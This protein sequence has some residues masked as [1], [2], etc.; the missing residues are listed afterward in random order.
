MVPA[1]S[2]SALSDSW[3]QNSTKYVP[4]LCQLWMAASANAPSLRAFGS[5]PSTSAAQNFFAGGCEPWLFPFRKPL[6]NGSSFQHKISSPLTEPA[7]IDSKSLNAPKDCATAPIFRVRRPPVL[8]LFSSSSSQIQKCTSAP[9]RTCL[10]TTTCRGCVWLIKNVGGLSARGIS[11]SLVDLP[12]ALPVV[13]STNLIWPVV[14]SK[15]TSASP[16]P[17]TAEIVP[18]LKEVRPATCP[19]DV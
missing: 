9:G 1:D 2:A 3:L 14:T 16:A 8:I 13:R 11:G 18:W 12:A 7:E 6:V 10:M 19:A 4:M 5:L 17:H 15:A